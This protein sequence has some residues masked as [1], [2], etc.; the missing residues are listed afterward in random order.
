MPSGKSKTSGSEKGGSVKN[1]FSR[2]PP[3]RSRSHTTGG[4]RHSSMI[5]HIEKPGAN[6]SLPSSS[7]ITR[8]APSRVPSSSMWSKSSSAA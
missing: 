3:P 7:R 5:V 4:L 1:P 8:F 2:S 6:T